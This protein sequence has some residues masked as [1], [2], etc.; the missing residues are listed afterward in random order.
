MLPFDRILVES[1]A[2]FMVPAEYRGKRNKPEFLPS[3]VWFLSEILQMAPEEAA[4]TTYQN[5]CR[6]F[7]LEP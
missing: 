2:P 5:A 7:R 3:T 6:F 1:E 4:E